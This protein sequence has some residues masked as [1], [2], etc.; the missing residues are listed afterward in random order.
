MAR[1]WRSVSKEV[2]NL[3]DFL[4]R[5]VRGQHSGNSIGHINVGPRK[6]FRMESEGTISAGAYPE[7]QAKRQVHIRQVKQGAHFFG[8]LVSA[9]HLVAQALA[10][11]TTKR[12]DEQTN[13]KVR[14][15]DAATRG[16]LHLYQGFQFLFF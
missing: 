15:M 2:R 11:T 6:F 8:F 12:I 4:R 9:V 5:V 3:R 10:V 7:L 13:N 1:V 14:C 16:N